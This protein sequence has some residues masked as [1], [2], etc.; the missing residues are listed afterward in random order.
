[1]VGK[2][3]LFKQDFSEGA[4][5][6]DFSREELEMYKKQAY[7]EGYEAGAAQAQIELRHIMA[8]LSQQIDDVLSV[9]HKAL[10][11]ATEIAAKVCETLFPKFSEEGARTEVVGIV[12]NI[13]AK[14]HTES[15]YRIQCAKEVRDDLESALAPYKD[16]MKFVVEGDENFHGSD[17]AITWDNGF[18][19]R[20]EIE[21]YEH[22]KDV[23]EA[24]KIQ[25]DG[26]SR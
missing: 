24:H 3:F 13:F 12:E 22:I 15:F 26:E 18:I 10:T 11:Y 7:L 17:V 25:H 4:P 9:R 19:W 5:Q 23:L 6:E 1:M 8:K 20:N 16:T 2:H 14:L 21:L